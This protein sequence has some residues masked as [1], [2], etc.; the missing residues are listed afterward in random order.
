MQ[1]SSC[2]GETTPE[3]AVGSADRP[4]STREGAT[5]GR[6]PMGPMI[7]LHL[8]LALALERTL[9]SPH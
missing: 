8:C 7:A 1:L 4:F 5:H 3:A 2:L 9:F 6:E